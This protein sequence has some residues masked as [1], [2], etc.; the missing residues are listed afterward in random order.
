MRSILRFARG[1]L[2]ACL[3]M[4]AAPALAETIAVADLPFEFRAGKMTLPA[5]EYAFVVEP[6]GRSMSVRKRSGGHLTYMMVQ[7]ETNYRRAG[8]R[9][10][11]LQKLG[12]TY[13]LSH[14]W[15]GGTDGYRLPSS[16]A[17]REAEISGLRPEMT[18]VPLRVVRHG[19]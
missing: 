15:T 18:L 10:L 3:A 14:I 12:G 13:Y 1:G 19:D 11:V 6:T 8:V 17:M 4:I 16:R 2:L 7:S 9:S 5:G